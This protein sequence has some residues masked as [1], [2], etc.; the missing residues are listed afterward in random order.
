MNS[1]PLQACEKIV[2]NT[3][4]GLG[5]AF[6][7]DKTTCVTLSTHAIHLNTRQTNFLGKDS[8]PAPEA[9]FLRPINLKRRNPLN[10]PSRA[11]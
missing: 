5:Y 6:Y 11:L 9:E 7:A 10:T 3:I 4:K 2:S 8:I 1:S